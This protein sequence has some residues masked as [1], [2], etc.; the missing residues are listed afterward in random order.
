M[1]H[2][3]KKFF[4]IIG[5]KAVCPDDAVKVLHRLFNGIIDDDI[6]VLLCLRQLSSRNGKTVVDR[7]LVLGLPS[8]QPL[9]KLF[10]ARRCDKDEPVR[11][12]FGIW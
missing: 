7:L 12:A 5:L 11:C 9:G 1:I 10:K 8:A 3:I 6:V 2:L 4:H